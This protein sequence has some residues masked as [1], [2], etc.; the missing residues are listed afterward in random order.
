MASADKK[1]W[2]GALLAYAKAIEADDAPDDVRAMA[3]Y[4]RAL[5]LAAEGKMDLALSDLKA[6]MKMPIPMQGVK[7]AAKRRLD[8]LEHRRDAAAQHDRRSTS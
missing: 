8:R 3:L 2:R 7:L 4:N 6:V 5:L 1:D